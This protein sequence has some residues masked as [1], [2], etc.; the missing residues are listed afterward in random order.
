MFSHLS[1]AAYALIGHEK[2]ATKDLDR[3]MFS[4]AVCREMPNLGE[5]CAYF[6]KKAL[7][8]RS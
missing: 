7:E 3:A 8:P 1:D 2:E 6:K 4:P 5:R